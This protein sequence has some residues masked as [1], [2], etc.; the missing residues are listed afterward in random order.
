MATSS[1]VGTSGSGPPRQPVEPPPPP[2]TID[3]MRPTHSFFRSLT[4]AGL[5]FVAAACPLIAADPA[6]AAPT[7]AEIAAATQW[8]G[9]VISVEGK[10]DI[11]VDLFP[12]DAPMTVA[13]F[14]N[15][16]SSGFYDH[17]TF[18]RVV[19]G[20][21]IQ[22]GDP[23]TKPGHTGD[24]GTGGPGYRIAGEVNR[25]KHLPGT[26]AMA[27]SGPNTAGSQF[28]LTLD[29]TPNLDGRYTTFGRVRTGKDMALCRQVKIGDRFTVKLI[30]AEP[31]PAAGTNTEATP[32]PAK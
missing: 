29:A 30:K 13:N 26:L 4:L 16:A 22:G 21:V 14:A 17:C 12:K 24:A 11:T 10:G 3:T 20:F 31:A 5:A 28:Y 8:V 18:H 7:A 19:P 9:A 15:L 25:Q 2:I 6:P 1:I 27:D 23:N 32:V